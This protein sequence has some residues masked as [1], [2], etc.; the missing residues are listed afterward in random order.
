MSA[1]PSLTVA[2][3]ELE[4]D[5]KMLEAECKAFIY[6]FDEIFYTYRLLSHKSSYIKL[7]D[8]IFTLK[9][10]EKKDLCFLYQCITGTLPRVSNEVNCYVR[11]KIENKEFNSKLVEDIIYKIISLH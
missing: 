9:S 11:E 5:T 2:L 3:H 8:K 10:N 6:K 4:N 7:D 1:A